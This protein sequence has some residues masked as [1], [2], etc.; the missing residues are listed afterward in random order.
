M[1]QLWIQPWQD[2]T[3]QICGA[4]KLLCASHT[5]C[6]TA[7]LV[8]TGTADNYWAK[9]FVLHL[10]FLQ[11]PIHTPIPILVCVLLKQ[12]PH[13]NCNS[14]YCELRLGRFSLSSGKPHH[15][16]QGYLYPDY[17][18]VLTYESCYG[19]LLP[20]KGIHFGT[21]FIEISLHPLLFTSPRE[22]HDFYFVQDFLITMGTNVFQVLL[23]PNWKRKS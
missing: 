22:I 7:V 3:A 18:L 12:A 15:L 20:Y 4:I 23:H 6:N 5:P 1:L 13:S 17:M 11:I 8:K 21:Q 9:W 10:G 16:C 14:P 2:I 19:S